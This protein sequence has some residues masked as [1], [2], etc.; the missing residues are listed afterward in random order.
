MTSAA[1]PRLIRGAPYFPVA[2]AERTAAYYE[3]VLGFRREYG[4]GSP[5]QFVILSR[6]GHAI[7]LRRV[8]DPAAIRPSEAQGGTWDAFFWVSDVEALHLE[9][10]SR[11]ADFA[12]LPIVQAAYG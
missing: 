7:M 5:L 1:S 2:D 9:F 11:D 6:D 3:S 12:Y 10:T 4:A 8:A